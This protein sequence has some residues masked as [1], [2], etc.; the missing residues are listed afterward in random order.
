MKQ[1]TYT[2]AIADDVVRHLAGG[3]LLIDWCEAHKISRFTV[4]QWR[5]DH[6]DFNAR[7]ARARDFG[8]EILEEMAIKAARTKDFN[9]ER[10]TQTIGDNGTTSTTTKSDNVARS[11]LEAETYLK[12]VARR[13]GAKIQLSG[14]K[15]APIRIERDLPP[16]TAEQVLEIA[17][18]KYDD[19]QA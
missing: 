11:R 12:V 10:E 18:M 19:D 13:K 17:R 2:E 9:V 14:D 16:L 1:S 6:P 15:E 4:N 7:F 3:G 5:D 8:D